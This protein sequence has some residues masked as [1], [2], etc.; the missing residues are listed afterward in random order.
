MQNTNAIN[1]PPYILG[2]DAGC[3]FAGYAANPFSPTLNVAQYAHWAIGYWH[4]TLAD[5]E[6]NLP[7]YAAPAPPLSALPKA[8]QT[9]A[10]AIIFAAKNAARLRPP[11]RKTGGQNALP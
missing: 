5:Q 9:P 6:G 1:P 3:N 10:V 4:S 7:K 11:K 8:G 2:F